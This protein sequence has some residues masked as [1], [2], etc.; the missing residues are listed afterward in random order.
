MV[1]SNR[2][3]PRR[4]Q[5]ISRGCLAVALT[6]HLPISLETVLGYQDDVLSQR[7][8]IHPDICNGRPV[9]RGTRIAVQGVLEFLAAGDSVQDVLDE[10]PELA[11]EDVQACLDD[12]S[13][14]MGNAYSIEAVA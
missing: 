11:I 13:R 2:P 10:F 4:A 8:T 3:F 12:E 7:I 6:S 14:L 1:I 9:M 5:W